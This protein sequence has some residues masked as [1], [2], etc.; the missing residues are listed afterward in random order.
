[1]VWGGHLL[2]VPARLHRLTL[3]FLQTLKQAVEACIEPTYSQQ[4][5]GCREKFRPVMA[6]LI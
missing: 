6:D 2:N 5:G 3:A 1:M 4:S